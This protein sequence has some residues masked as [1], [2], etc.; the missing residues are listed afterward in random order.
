MHLACSSLNDPIIRYL[1]SSGRCD[2]TIKNNDK[3][4]ARQVLDLKAKQA[5]Q[6]TRF[7]EIIDALNAAETESSMNPQE[8]S[9]NQTN[10]ITI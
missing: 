6:L 1:H 8:R 10:L 9:E 5:G 4:T 2:L 3:R 7:V